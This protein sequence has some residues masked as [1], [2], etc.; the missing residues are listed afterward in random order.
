M[1]KQL[2]LAPSDGERVAAGRERGFLQEFNET[3]LPASRD[4]EANRKMIQPLARS[5]E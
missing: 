4:S 1:P 3:R 5:A 2:P